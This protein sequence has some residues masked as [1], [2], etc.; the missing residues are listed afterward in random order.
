MN[1]QRRFV[2]GL[3]SVAVAATLLGC[4]TALAQFNEWEV[5]LTA[6]GLP[7]DQFA[8]GA[9]DGATLGYDE[10]LEDP[11]PPNLPG[12]W[13]GGFKVNGA[14]AGSLLVQDYHPTGL[15]SGI[16][17]FQLNAPAG[18]N[19]GLSWSTA[20]A[21]AAPNALSILNENG[22]TIVANMA[23]TGTH[24]FAV[25][26]KGLNRVFIA[27]GQAAPIALDDAVQMLKN[28]VVDIDVLANDFF[29]A[30][31]T[32]DIVAL[33]AGPDTNGTVFVETDLDGNPFVRYTPTAGFSGTATFTYKASGGLTTSAVAATVTV[34]VS[35]YVALQAPVP[36]PPAVPGEPYTFTAGATVDPSVTALSISFVL[37]VT[38][39]APPTL[40]T[41]APASLAVQGVG[42]GVPVLVDNG[43]GT[44]VI[45][46]NGV[47]PTSFSFDLLPPTQ[48][49]TA[50]SLIF[51]QAT[52]TAGDA[53]VETNLLSV[54]IP[55]KLSNL[56]V[57]G[58]AGGAAYN[59]TDVRLI[60][61]YINGGQ[62]LDSLMVGGTVHG[63]G[64][65]AEFRAKIA[66]MIADLDIDGS[67]GGAAYNSTDV[68]LIFNY[69]NGGQ[70]LD[71]LM[72]GGTVHGV[73]RAAEFRAK[74]AGMIGN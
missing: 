36:V 3:T 48:K 72:V 20:A 69:I 1:V 15:G 8:F 57:D 64:R 35:Q 23:V 47:I 10:T 22:G 41:V 38:A 28:G 67:A 73:G 58:S 66:G 60:F 27:M 50:T 34:R 59:S 33:T 13:T 19:V 42:A 54:G 21:A 24:T 51:D 14:P 18:Q 30:G 11:L 37:P 25:G 26:G 74:I 49:V 56:D 5:T 71:S 68:R 61:N 45:N 29:P 43:D 44:A 65:A 16:W 53:F 9:K 2:S 39:E 46:F 62:A 63:V 12:G 55:V 17:E 40:W 32:P 4:F 6:T 7:Y 52:G 70:A 31:S